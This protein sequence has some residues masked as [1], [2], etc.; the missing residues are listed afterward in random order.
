MSPVRQFFRKQYSQF[1]NQRRDVRY[2][3]V[4]L[5]AVPL[6]TITTIQAL[7]QGLFDSVEKPIFH[8]FN[9]LPVLIG[10]LMYLITQFGAFA[11]L[12]VWFG[13]TWYVINRRAAW[14]VLA[15]GV[16]GW[17]LAKVAKALVHRSRPQGLVDVVTLF[18]DHVYS[19][20]GYPSGHST[21]VAAVAGV[22][23]Y[24]VKPKYRKYLLLIVVLVGIS[25]M[26]LGAHL[27][28][29]VVGGWAL[30]ALVGALVSLLVGTSVQFISVARIKRALK[31][32]G[33][34]IRHATFASVDARGSRPIFIQDKNGTEYFGKV[35]GKQEHAADWLFKLYRFFRYKNM[36]AEEPY[37]DSRRNVE[38]ESFANMWA[39]QAGVRT[40]RVV[41]LVKIGT[42][43]LLIQE[44]VPAKPLTDFKRITQKTLEDAW[45]QVAQLHNGNM[46]HRDLRAANLMVDT[47]GK[48][49]MIDF[50]FAEVSPSKQRKSMD[51]AELL[52]SMALIVGP[53]RTTEAATKILDADTLKESLPFLQRSVFSGATTAALK[54]QK[55]TLP[56]LQQILKGR[57]G[58]SGEVD[59][60][61][62]DRLNGRKLLN[63]ML[64]AVFVYII[65]PQFK[66]FRGAMDYL[67]SMQY[68]W[69][70]AVALFSSL[71][72]VAAGAVYVA[73][74]SIPL[75][76]RD[77]S[78]VQL[79][80]SFVS[81]ILPGGLAST[82]LN[83]PLS[84][85]ARSV[86]SPSFEPHCGA[87]TDW[88]R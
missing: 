31:R 13:V 25:R 2:V 85:E 55:D 17:L 69:L 65:V 37:L 24:Q 50:G 28:L 78:L 14:T 67:D 47:H 76:L 84:Y 3:V 56:Q 5:W 20:F 64:L 22:L 34:D 32:R 39:K 16:S 74:A 23:F 62:V 71:T 60:A 45:R 35:F 30:G 72:Y 15:S 61:N 68:G 66:E 80:A 26:Y 81:K 43:W 46:A 59:E 82:S 4:L 8:F 42:H 36:Q 41:D 75:R 49:W 44:R 9:S 63:I 40:P 19:G 52:M 83:A 51:I 21:F 77:A 29:D 87:G 11:S 58:I 33:Y 70:V 7:N 6:F 88:R 1:L 10:A 86:D 12:P 27:P 54:E 57:L 38:I 48:V 18:R 79:A 73:L 53:E